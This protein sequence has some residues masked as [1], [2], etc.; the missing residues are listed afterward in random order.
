[1]KGIFTRTP[2]ASITSL[3][4]SL[5]VAHIPEDVDPAA[6]AA[7]FIKRLDSLSSED[8]TND[9]LWRDSFALTGT[10]RTFFSA[11]VIDAAWKDV[12]SRHHPTGFTL[13]PDSPPRIA[14][15]V[16][17][18]AWVDAGFTFETHGQPQT[19]C[20]GFIS[21]VPDGNGGWR[22]WLLRTILEELKGHGNPD[23]LEPRAEVTNGT[24]NGVNGHAETQGEAVNRTSNG[25][26]GHA[27]PSHF[28][29]VVIGA[30]QAGLGTAGRMKALGVSCLVVD[31][32]ARVGDNWM[33]RYDSVK[34]ELH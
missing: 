8:F 21:L 6:I 22:I 27:E 12:S 33:L 19:K 10:L 16:P 4:G 29:C 9:A 15:H 30:G 17:K 26:N 2:A 7:P 14:R 34:R 20:S 24:S 31:R 1:M 25:V 13:N 28:D 23:V 3:P 11:P 32:N 5:P 18:R